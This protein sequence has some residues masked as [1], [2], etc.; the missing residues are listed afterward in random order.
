[1]ASTKILN[2]FYGQALSFKHTQHI[3]LV[4]G[5]ELRELKSSRSLKKTIF[6]LLSVFFNTAPP[7]T[8]ATYLGVPDCF[9]QEV[10]TCFLLKLSIDIAPQSKEHEA[11][12]K[13]QS[14]NNTALLVATQ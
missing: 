9:T 12:L 8:F 11:S 3:I 5:R 7:N 10:S 14:N 13:F 6:I 2:C 1:M 4:E